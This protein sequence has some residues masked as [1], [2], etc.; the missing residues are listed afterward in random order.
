[1]RTSWLARVTEKLD[2]DHNMVIE[3]ITKIFLRLVSGIAKEQKVS[4]FNQ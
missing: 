4:N 2:P 3:D 1:M